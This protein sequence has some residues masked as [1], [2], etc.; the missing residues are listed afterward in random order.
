M[1]IQISNSHTD[2]HDRHP[3]Q[4]P[5][6]INMQKS[7]RPSSSKPFERHAKKNTIPFAV[8]VQIRRTPDITN[9]SSFKMCLSVPFSDFLHGL[10]P[11]GK[12]STN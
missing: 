6:G 12:R 10:I 5:V 11:E 4:I 9:A 2:R 1:I 3:L 7:E 8:T